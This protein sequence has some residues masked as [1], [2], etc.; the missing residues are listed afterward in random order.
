[1]SIGKRTSRSGFVTRA[2]AAIIAGVRVASALAAVLVASG[3]TSAQADEVLDWNVVLFQIVMSE[4]AGANLATSIA[5]S[6]PAAIMHLAVFEAVNAI[7]GGHE[8]YLGTISAPAGASPRAAAAAAAHGVLRAFFV[9]P[10]NV[11]LLDTALAISLAAIPDGRAED[12]GVAVGQAAA[13]AMVAARAGD[14][15]APPAFWVP[16]TADPG[17]WQTTPACPPLG[18]VFLHWR[19]VTP[20]GLASTDQFRSAPPPALTSNRYRKDFDEVKELGRFDS[21]ERPPDRADVAILYRDLLG[22]QTWNP[23][24]RQV[25]AAKGTSLA[26]NARTFALLNMAIHDALLAV[27]ETKY[28]YRFWRPETAI[29]RAD[30]DGNPQ[31]DPDPGWAPF[32]VTPCFPSYGSAHASAGGAARK[33][34]EK[35]FGAAGHDFTVSHP[36]QPISITYT[37]FSQVTRDIDDARIYGGIHF[38]FDQVQGARQGRRIGSYL[39]ENLLRKAG[40]DDDE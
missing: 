8:P 30:E 31:T 19:N 22:P 27:Q 37:Q 17:E 3:P 6:R 40:G 2:E 13:A 29:H 33:I 14:G 16:P 35:A 25:A 39:Y 10:A 4:P 12:D 15:S 7:E 5:T 38:G 9:S 28:H 1:M 21:L 11:A 36:S 32:I 18:G 34:L 20:F 23:I 24:A 26:E